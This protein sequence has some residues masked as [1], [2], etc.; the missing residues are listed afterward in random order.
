MYIYLNSSSGFNR[1]TQKKKKSDAYLWS[2][3]IFVEFVVPQIV[4]TDVLQYS[5]HLPK[6]K[7][8]DAVRRSLWRE[9]N[10]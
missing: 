3:N 5:D 6:A 7:E 10:V 8:V 2:K 4:V 1:I 9:N